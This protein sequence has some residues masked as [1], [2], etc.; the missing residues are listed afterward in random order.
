MSHKG[1]GNGDVLG[2]EPVSDLLEDLLSYIQHF[3][4]SDLV[5]FFLFLKVFIIVI[6]GCFLERVFGSSLVSAIPLR[7]RGSL[8]FLLLL[9]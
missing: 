1:L 5:S 7:C 9:L 6:L 3:F 4:F 8:F 2:F